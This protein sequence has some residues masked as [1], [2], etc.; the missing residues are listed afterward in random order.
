[1]KKTTTA[2][3]LTIFIIGIFLGFTGCRGESRVNEKKPA[4]KH[5]EINKDESSK[6]A[7]ENAD[8]EVEKEGK[9]SEDSDRVPVDDSDKKRDKVKSEDK[10]KGEEKEPG[11]KEA[12]E[13]GNIFAVIKTEKGDMKVELYPDVAPNT[14]VN[15]V[16]LSKKGFYDN[17]TFHRVVPGFVIQGGCPLGSG[18]GDPGYAIP[19]EFNEKKH[20]KG[21]LSMARSTHPDSAGCQFYICLDAQPGLDG[22]Y[23]VF[24][25]L[26][27]G[28]DIPGKI[29]VDDKIKTVVIEGELPAKLKGKK[30]KKSDF[31]K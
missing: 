3:I 19:A 11:K 20:L 25:Q 1:L 22:K 30:V 28:E 12:A 6:P 14:V 8:K 21:T 2:I 27:E 15:F 5:D 10:D 24:G 7:V 9:H 23:T 29:V 18:T 31:K 4:V 26:V 13:K 16:T 17:L